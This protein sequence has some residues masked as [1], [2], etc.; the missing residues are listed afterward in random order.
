MKKL[1]LLSL[2][3]ILAG[4][5]LNP[6]YEQPQAPVPSEYNAA[7]SALPAGLLSGADLGW[8]EVIREPRLRSLIELALTNNRDMLI[9]IQRVEES[10]ALYGVQ[11]SDL[12][13]HIGA[14]AQESADRK[15]V[16]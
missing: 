9:A 14:N 8:Q 12:L 13:P 5:S 16:V 3:L 6:K 7:S 1:S 11:R 10:R 2:S 15:S 4:C